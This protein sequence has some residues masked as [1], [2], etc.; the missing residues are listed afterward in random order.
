MCKELWNQ[1]D[2]SICFLCMSLKIIV[3]IFKLKLEPTSNQIPMLH[4][5]L[6]QAH[7]FLLLE[8]LHIFR[9]VARSRKEIGFKFCFNVI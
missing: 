9:W 7:F 1:F 4:N 6:N 8:T 3:S 5:I 2:L